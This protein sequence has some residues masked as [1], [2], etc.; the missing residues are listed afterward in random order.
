MP[1]VGSSAILSIDYG[2]A[3]EAL[4][5]RFVSGLRYIY[6]GVPS[7][8]YAAFLAAPSKGEFFNAAIRD[9]Y[10][11]VREDAGG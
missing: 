8:V 9:R 6:S 10:A 11:F 7:G 4:G 3:S 5:I 1:A 2:P